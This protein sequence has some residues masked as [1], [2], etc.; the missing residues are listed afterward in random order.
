MFIL[1]LHILV[2]YPKHS[3]LL[4]AICTAVT[5]L[6]FPRMALSYILYLL[7]SM[8]TYDMIAQDSSHVNFFL[9]LFMRRVDEVLS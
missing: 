2:S 7:L 8:P 4:N 3:V 1:N 5:T 9:I 6:N